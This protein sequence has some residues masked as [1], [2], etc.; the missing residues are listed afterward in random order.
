MVVSCGADVGDVTS[1]NVTDFE[2]PYGPSFNWSFSQALL[3]ES[4]SDDWWDVCG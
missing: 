4:F 2:Y 1:L 3:D